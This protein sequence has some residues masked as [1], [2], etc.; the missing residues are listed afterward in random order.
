M[1]GKISA[2]GNIMSLLDGSNY[3]S[4]NS[5]EGSANAF[6][7]LFYGCASLTSSPKLPAT[8]LS[9]GCYLKMFNGCTSLTKAPNLPATTLSDFCYL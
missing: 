8:T 7:G 6:A 5:L 2:S 4:M 3:N 1:S 9:N